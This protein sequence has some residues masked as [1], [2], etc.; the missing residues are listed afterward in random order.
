[1]K[2]IILPILIAVSFSACVT[3]KKYS[4][5]ST[6]S[7]GYR[8]KA[9]GCETE[10]SKKNNELEISQA[11]LTSLEEQL[12]HLKK[13]NTNLLDRMADLSIISKTESESIR[14]SLDAINERYGRGAIQLGTSGMKN[15]QRH[16]L[17]RQDKLSPQYTTKWSDLPVVWA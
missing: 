16:W 8:T 12:D 5:L 4:T 3:K 6:A 2:R 10:L 15:N 9:E 13:T 11:K 17:S 7:E 14:K 1:M